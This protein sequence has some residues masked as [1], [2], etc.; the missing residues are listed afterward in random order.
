[1]KLSDYDYALPD[2]LIAQRPADRRDCSRLMVMHRKDGN[3]E[4]RRFSD[5]IEY[6]QPGD[7]LAVNSTRVIPARLLGHKHATGGAAEILLLRPESANLWNCLVRPGRRLMTGAR[8][9]LGDGLMEAEIVECRSGGQ[10]LVRF[11]HQGGF[12]QILEKVGQV[13]LPPYIVRQPQEADKN[14][15]QTVYAK[16]PGAVAAPTAGLHFTSELMEKVRMQGVEI[17]EVILHVGWGTFKGVEADD[18]RDH[19]MDAEYYEISPGAAETLKNAKKLKRR[20]VA[21]G[22]TTSRALESFGQTGELSG[23]T[24]IFIYPPYQFRLL[25]SLI[26]NFHLPRSTLLML[27]SALAG[28]DSLMKAYQEAI[29]RR[30]RFYSYGDAMMII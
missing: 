10:R 14:R 6:L 5:I 20:I 8:V 12:Y 16:E 26:T 24:E 23:W 13:P 27:V 17:L 18:I 11:S 2:E 29:H 9:I 19:R 28:R 1:M 7:I 15:Y 21:V 25:D 4:H 30:Y 22:T 3:L